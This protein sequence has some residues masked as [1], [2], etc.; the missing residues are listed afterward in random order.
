MAQ[1]ELV[2]FEGEVTPEGEVPLPPKKAPLELVPISSE[3]DIPFIEI[4]DELKKYERS[5]T[6]RA[7]IGA[8]Y[9]Q[10]QALRDKYDELQVNRV[11]KQFSSGGVYDPSSTF[12]MNSVGG[13]VKAADMKGRSDLFSEQWRKFKDAYPKGSLV[14]VETKFG[15]T[16]LIG[17]ATPNE[18]YRKVGSWQ[19]DIAG[20]AVNEVTVGAALG[21]IAATTGGLGLVPAVLLAG[22]GA[23]IGSL[24][25]DK[26]EDVRGYQDSPWTSIAKDAAGEFLINGVFE[27]LGMYVTGAKGKEGFLRAQNKAKFAKLMNETGT[28]IFKGEAA[29]ALWRAVYDVTRPL[30]TRAQRN[31]ANRM[32]QMREQLIARRVGESSGVSSDVLSDEKLRQAIVDQR[33]ETMQLQGLTP[34][35]ITKQEIGTAMRDAEDKLDSYL[36]EATDRLYGYAKKSADEEVTQFTL[37]GTHTDIDKIETGRFAYKR[38]ETKTVDGVPITSQELQQTN[39]PFADPKLKALVEEIK[40]L[41]P[42]VVAN[43]KNNAFVAVMDLRSRAGALMNEAKDGQTKA[44]A[45]AI[46]NSLSES[47]RNPIGGSPDFLNKWS[48]AN[49]TYHEAMKWRRA[50]ET[51][52]A[53]GETNDAEAIAAQYLGPDQYDTLVLLK[54]QLDSMAADGAASAEAKRSGADAW[55]K[56][57]RGYFVA[58]TGSPDNLLNAPETMAKMG[59]EQLD[60]MIDPPIQKAIIRAS[61]NYNQ[62][63]SGPVQKLLAQNRSQAEKFAFLASNKSVT[64]AELEAFV[65]QVGGRDSEA[66]AGLRAAIF[67]RLINEGEVRIKTEAGQLAVDPRKLNTKINEMFRSGRMNALFSDEDKAAFEKWQEV[68]TV[69]QKANSLGAQE[70]TA[71]TATD[72]TPR[73][74]GQGGPGYLVKIA[75][76]VGNDWLGGIMS[77]PLNVK[78]VLAAAENNEIKHTIKNALVVQGNILSNLQQQAWTLNNTMD[79]ISPHDRNGNPINKEVIQEYYRT[80]PPPSNIGGSVID[81]LNGVGGAAKEYVPFMGSEPAPA[82]APGPQGSLQPA[83]RTGIMSTTNMAQAMPPRP[84]A[85]MAQPSPAQGSKYAAL[86]PRDSLGAMAASGGI[87]SLKG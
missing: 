44:E 41:D 84:T 12:D 25:G 24:T 16:M 46:W 2:P 64:E 4:E 27:G 26:I 83:P 71:Q 31:E 57:R 48:V 73:S 33:F 19:A 32:F 37:Q 51:R 63:Q 61:E 15:G 85:P 1:L 56:L 75:G 45:T 69:V 6:N 77:K 38:P 62:M 21:T 14:P 78:K 54:K 36:T 86:F 82:P 11:L 43:P 50:K 20:A 79:D 42:T 68:L 74:M 3:E 72:F 87:A 5:P 10:K 52:Y 49:E 13:F 28:P 18:P 55:E 70:A 22:T 53:L 65:A 39:K 40:S 17:R 30:S 34:T 8:F 58:L 60:L 23:A 7:E 35:G 81:F 80:N 9:K 66:A 76:I 59:Q 67:D 29:G 47:L